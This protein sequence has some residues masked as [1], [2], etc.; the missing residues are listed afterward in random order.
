MASQS[1]ST[2]TG[3]APS[4]KCDKLKEVYHTSC[5]P[6]WVSCSSVYLLPGTHIINII[7]F[8]VKYFVQVKYFDKKRVYD[9]YIKKLEEQGYQPLPAEDEDTKR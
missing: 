3:D 7:S 4:N 2:S 6:A 9:E 5:R 8:G 1:T